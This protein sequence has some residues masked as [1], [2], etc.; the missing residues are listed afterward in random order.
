MGGR[1]PHSR[2]GVY[3]LDHRDEIIFSFIGY[4]VSRKGNIDSI[5]DLPNNHRN[6]LEVVQNLI[7]KKNHAAIK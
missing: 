3:F 6:L 1:D 2:F 7:K 5:E 4:A